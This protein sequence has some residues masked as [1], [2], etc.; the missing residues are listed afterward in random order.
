MVCVKQVKIEKKQNYR[1]RNRRSD[2]VQHCH[3]RK[4]KSDDDN[5]L[6]DKACIV[7]FYTASFPPSSILYTKLLGLRLRFVFA[8][9]EFSVHKKTDRYNR[10]KSRI[11]RTLMV[12]GV[13]FSLNTKVT[14]FIFVGLQYYIDPH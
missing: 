9:E 6:S 1:H 13:L 7:S 2:G 8:A 5:D 14:P 10:A 12:I 11:R 3:E 4:S